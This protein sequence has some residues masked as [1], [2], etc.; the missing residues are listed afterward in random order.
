ME[1]LYC[2]VRPENSVIVSIMYNRA[3]NSYHFVNL[4][5]GHICKC[6]FETVD[7][8]IADME[9]LKSQGKIISYHKI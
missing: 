8:A 1:N 2:V 7:D 9:K 4:T 6:A 3:N 5:H